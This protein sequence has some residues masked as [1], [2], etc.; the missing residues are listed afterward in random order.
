MP[1]FAAAYAYDLPR[2]SF[3]CFAISDDIFAA[4]PLYRS[5]RSI[6]RYR[7]TS[8]HILRALRFAIIISIRSMAAA[9]YAIDTLTLIIKAA[10][11]AILP[12]ALF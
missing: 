11:D 10:F 2:L 5:S 12:D 8:R 3:A 9:D 1:L 4:T 7:N 6:L